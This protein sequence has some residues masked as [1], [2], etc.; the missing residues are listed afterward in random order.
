[1]GLLAVLEG[2]L[3]VVGEDGLTLEQISDVLEIDLDRLLNKRVGKMKYKE[4]SKLKLILI[5]SIS[6][7]EEVLE[8]NSH[9]IEDLIYLFYLNKWIIMILQK[10]EPII[11]SVSNIIIH[12]VKN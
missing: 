12:N 2:L 3:F 11:I 5:G 1:M 10:I 7:M 4:I 6:I 9:Y 8:H